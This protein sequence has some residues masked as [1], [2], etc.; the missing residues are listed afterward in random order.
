MPIP[1]LT[2][3]T[4]PPFTALPLTTTPPSLETPQENEYYLL[5]QIT[6]NMTLTKPTLILSDLTGTSFALVFASRPG[7][8]PDTLDFKKLGYKKGATLVL[9]NVKRTPPKEG[10]QSRGF[11]SISREEEGGV[12]VVPGGLEGVGR[13]LGL[14]GGR[15]LKRGGEGGKGGCESCGNRTRNEGGGELM[16]CTG[17]GEVE[18]CCKECQVKGWD[19]GGHKGDCKLIKAIRAI[20]P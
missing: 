1:N 18:Y 6:E 19:E 20:W 17:C 9:P 4:F 7:S 11:V 10:D 13:V 5:A 14:L 12:R 2:P 15:D 8:G 3:T 16:K